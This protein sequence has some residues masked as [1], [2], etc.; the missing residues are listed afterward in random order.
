MQSVTDIVYQNLANAIVLQAVEDYRNALKGIS[1]NR[2]PPEI[3]ILEL[4]KFFHSEYFKTLTKVNGDYLI[5]KLKK[6]HKENERSNNES[7]TDTI[8]T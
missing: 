2:Y 1:Y 4:E 8:D 3:A 6:E 5:D 7:N